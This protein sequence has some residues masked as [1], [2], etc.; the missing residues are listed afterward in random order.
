MQLTAKLLQILPVQSGTGKNGLWQKHS[1]IVETLDQY[2]NQICLTIWG[3]EIDMS[4]IKI[5]DQL[6]FD[7]FI[8]S[9]EYNGKWY[10]NIIA[11]ELETEDIITTEYE[12]PDEL[13]KE[14]YDYFREVNDSAETVGEKIKSFGIVINKFKEKFKKETSKELNGTDLVEIIDYFEKGNSKQNVIGVIVSEDV[15][16]TASKIIDVVEEAVFQDYLDKW[17]TIYDMKP[18]SP[19][20]MVKGISID[21]VSKY[22]SLIIYNIDDVILFTAEKLKTEKIEDIKLIEYIESFHKGGIDD[23][24]DEDANTSQSTTTESETTENTFLT[25]SDPFKP[26]PGS[27]DKLRGKLRPLSPGKIQEGDF[28]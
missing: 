28:L 19:A 2:H 4:K 14:I 17:L 15:N 7:Y 11:T 22:Q 20:T 25:S 24:I 5:G 21:L 8:Q 6:K 27:M 23:K 12:I 16:N 9:K 18:M 10:T 13:A 26:E 1:L 3:D